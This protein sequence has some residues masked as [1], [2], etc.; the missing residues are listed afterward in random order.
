MR[1]ALE[2]VIGR[3]FSRVSFHCT[4]QAASGTCS[5]QVA[6]AAGAA[7]IEDSEVAAAPPRARRASNEEGGVVHEAPRCPVDDEARV[8]EHPVRCSVE[9]WCTI[10]DASDSSPEQM[11]EPPLTRD[12]SLKRPAASAAVTLLPPPKRARRVTR[13]APL[14]AVAANPVVKS[15]GSSSDDDDEVGEPLGRPL[16]AIDTARESPPALFDAMT[17]PTQSSEEEPVRIG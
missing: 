14:S 1:L 13:K 16:V 12:R 7:S 15:D 11:T 5:F 6:A 9:G 2:R 3:R 17:S 10:S 8:S 4:A